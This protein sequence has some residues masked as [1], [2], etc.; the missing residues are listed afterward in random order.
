[1]IIMGVE[2]GTKIV[3]DSIQMDENSKRLIVGGKM[4]CPRCK[5]LQ[6]VLSFM[7]MEESPEFEDETNPIYKCSL[8]KWIFSPGD[9]LLLSKLLDEVMKLREEIETLRNTEVIRL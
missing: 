6:P 3:Y 7:R 4:H 9:P 8:C 2:I 1:M 5:K